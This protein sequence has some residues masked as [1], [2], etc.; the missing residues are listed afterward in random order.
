M[1]TTSWVYALL[2]INL[3]TLLGAC[4]KDSPPT[5]LAPAPLLAPSPAPAAEATQPRQGGVDGGG[6][7]LIQ[8]TEA[9]VKSAV[10]LAF[11]H[12]VP[13]ALYNL[14]LSMDSVKDPS[15][16]RIL[17]K[18]YSDDVGDLHWEKN[19]PIF[20]DLE[21][22][23]YELKDSDTCLDQ[24]NTPHTMS[25]A[26]FEQGQTI[27]VSMK[28]L[29]AIPA[30]ELNHHITA[31]LVHELAHHFGFNEHDATRIQYFITN[32]FTPLVKLPEILT[33]TLN[34]M[35]LNP[36]DPLSPYSHLHW[37]QMGKAVQKI[38]INKEL[39]VCEI[40]LRQSEEDRLE[41]YNKKTKIAY[42]TV[43]LK[44]DLRHLQESVSCGPTPGK[45]GKMK[46][47]TTF[48]SFRVDRI[49]G[50]DF[51]DDPAKV[52]PVRRADGKGTETYISQVNC[53]GPEMLRYQDYLR[54]F[55]GGA[56]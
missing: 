25:V 14:G 28:R 27:C 48:K 49:R 34:D 13:T 10:E 36:N 51:S 35:E 54:V 53:T 8:S 38:E 15:V 19:Q 4:Q 3:V 44:L 7:N 40:I 43:S 32:K 21:N 24:E 52:Y 50:N 30:E 29:R 12:Y 16:F 42:K 56:Q 20:Q 1:K 9:E 55:K 46:C 39:P 33:V 17:E 2:L 31:L 47:A 23:S 41:E 26:K 5:Q 22:T 18:F 11:S 37:I 6:G 45:K